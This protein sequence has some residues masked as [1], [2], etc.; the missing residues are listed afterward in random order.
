MPESIVVLDADT[1]SSSVIADALYAWGFDPLVLDRAEGAVD[2][3]MKRSAAAVV[4]DL[5]LP[6]M[7]G[8]SFCRLMRGDAQLASIP[9]IVATAS[10]RERPIRE[11]ALRRYGVKA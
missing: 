2:V 4:L 5:A 8:L 10:Y 6:G 9:V 3:V 11:L 7:D 1:R